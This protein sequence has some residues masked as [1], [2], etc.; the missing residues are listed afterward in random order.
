M[1]NEEVKAMVLSQDHKQLLTNYAKNYLAIKQIEKEMK[2]EVDT[3]KKVMIENNV[4][5]IENGEYSLTLSLVNGVKQVGKVDAEFTKIVLDTAK[6]N[7][8]FILTGK[9]PKG[10]E[11]TLTYKLNAP[12]ELK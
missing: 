8:H 5:N 4:K 9:L 10:V 3:L 6:A 2:A 11:K 12:K 7:S 1:S